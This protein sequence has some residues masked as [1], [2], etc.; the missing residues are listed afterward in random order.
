MKGGLEACHLYRKAEWAL[1]S[2]VG[3]GTIVIVGTCP[4]EGAW[5][6]WSPGTAVKT[7]LYIFQ[8]ALRTVPIGSHWF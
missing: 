1:K 3:F 6:L 5:H 4:A 2:P 7:S 8:R